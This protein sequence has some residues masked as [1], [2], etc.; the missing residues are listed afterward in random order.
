MVVKK[1]DD[2]DNNDDNALTNYQVLAIEK[3]Y[4]YMGKGRRSDM[5]VRMM[6]LLS[7]LLIR[8]QIVGSL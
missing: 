3:L 7:L 6:I 1:E 2:D 8:C 5:F 4:R